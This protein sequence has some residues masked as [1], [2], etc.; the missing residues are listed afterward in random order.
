MIKDGGGG[1]MGCNGGSQ[2]G[3]KREEGG[4]KKERKKGGVGQSP[5][6]KTST[7]VKLQ[8]SR[9]LLFPMTA[10]VPRSAEIENNQNR[11]E[12]RAHRGP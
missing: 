11:E 1:T 3:G 8:S 10:A 6:N 7:D 9:T 4:R 2:R 12:Y 5:R